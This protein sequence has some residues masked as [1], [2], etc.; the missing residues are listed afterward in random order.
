MRLFQPVL[1]C[2]APAPRNGTGNQNYTSDRGPTDEIQAGKS[3]QAARHRSLSNGYH[4][5]DS[6]RWL[7]CLEKLSAGPGKTAN[8]AS[9]SPTRSSANHEWA[10]FPAGCAGRAAGAGDPICACPQTGPGTATSRA[11]SDTGTARLPTSRGN[12]SGS[13]GGAGP[14]GLFP[15][16]HRRSGRASDSRGFAGISGSPATSCNRPVG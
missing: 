15:G 14:A 11:S 6:G 5:R 9:G 3:A 16:C 12:Y 8:F 7:V 2:A 10:N 1:Q 4:N 13:A